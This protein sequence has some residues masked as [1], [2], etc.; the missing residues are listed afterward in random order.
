[1]RTLTLCLI[2]CAGCTTTVVPKHVEAMA[3][4][5]GGQKDSGFV[6]YSP[7]GR[8]IITSATRDKYNALVERYGQQFLVPLKKDD[9]LTPMPN[10]QWLIDKERL[11][12]FMEMADWYR[13]K[14]E[15][16]R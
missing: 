1:M 7:D 6:G 9:G 3:T 2:L 8:G 15:L 13:M 12:K 11:E 16:V 4:Y 14:R 10:G 5:D